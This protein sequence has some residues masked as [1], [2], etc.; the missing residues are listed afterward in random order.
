MVH[1]RDGLEPS[2]LDQNIPRLWG[3]LALISVLKFSTGSFQQGTKS[4]EHCF[5]KFGFR[6]EL[7]SCSPNWNIEL[8][9]PGQGEPGEH[10]GPPVLCHAGSPS[11][12]NIH[13]W[14]LGVRATWEAHTV[15]DISTHQRAMH[16]KSVNTWIPYHYH[17]II[18]GLGVKLDYL[19][20]L[21]SLVEEQ[22]PPN[23]FSQPIFH[24]FMVQ[25]LLCN[26]GLQ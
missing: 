17:N 3:S 23:F 6:S 8:P 12:G 7:C 18:C 19:S 10:K 11:Q 26:W 15:W 4:S 2:P 22:I 5:G 1:I 9:K 13:A 21:N 14:D 16:P 20:H 25:S 24:C